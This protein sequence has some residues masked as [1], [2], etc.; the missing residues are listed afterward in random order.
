[1]LPLETKEAV[2]ANSLEVQTRLQG[3]N[4]DSVAC[5]Y[6]KDVD[7]FS[8]NAKKF[9]VVVVKQD[10]C[11]HLRTAKG[12]YVLH[13]HPS[14]NYWHGDCAG[15]KVR[16]VLNAVTGILTYWKKGAKK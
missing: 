14:Q 12:D 4:R 15:T 9:S 1:M 10:N 8:D 7:H 16:V 6:G 11:L 2:M 5:Q 3:F 13:K